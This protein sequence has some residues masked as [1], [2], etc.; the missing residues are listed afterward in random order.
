MKR[1]LAIGL[2]LALAACASSKNQ[3]YVEH[4]K[5][6]S[7]V[8]PGS[9]LL[10]KLEGDAPLE[11]YGEVDLDNV[12]ADHGSMMYV[13]NTPGVFAASILAHA[14]IAGSAND[15]QKAKA[16]EEA[17]QVL[18]PY[19]AV[20]ELMTEA[21]LVESALRDTSFA[22]YK[23]MPWTETA[24]SSLSVVV[25]PVFLMSQ[26]QRTLTLK[27]AVTLIANGNEQ[28]PAYQNLIEVVSIA[29][30]SGEILSHDAVAATTADLFTTSLLILED[31]LQGS[32]AGKSE[33]K[34]LSYIHG[35]HKKFERGVVL[36]EQCDRMTFRSLRGW[37]KSVPRANGDCDLAEKVVS[38]EG[39]SA[40][41]DSAVEI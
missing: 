27:N 28:A 12:N 4:V 26:D 41:A 30:G 35:G 18:L 11:F 14:V 36:S 5:R 21:G 2:S 32:H 8:S 15:S 38:G 7:D 19:A 39:L 17:N 33:Q 29:D 31:E 6:T 23:F 1:L 10:V 22:A 37:I 25:K 3:N 16:Q 24:D 34:T 20:I 13:A 40:G 9:M